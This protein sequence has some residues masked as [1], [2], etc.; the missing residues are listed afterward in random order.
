[1]SALTHQPGRVAVTV[2]QLANDMNHIRL[3]KPAG[4]LQVSVLLNGRAK[5]MQCTLQQAQLKWNIVKT[6]W[7]AS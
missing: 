6:T 2:E 5:R 4:Q 7:Y 1:M 3:K